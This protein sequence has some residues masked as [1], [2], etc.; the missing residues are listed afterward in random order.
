MKKKSELVR[1]ENG[2][3]KIV[4]DNDFW[5]KMK[6]QIFLKKEIEKGDESIANGKFHTRADFQRKYGLEILMR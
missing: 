6:Y 2:I 4:I 1:A 3:S 5:E